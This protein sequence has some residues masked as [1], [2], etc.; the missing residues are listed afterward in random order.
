[1]RL[2]LLYYGLE[3]CKGYSAYA[4]GWI[5]EKIVVQFLGRQKISVYSRC[6]D[7]SSH[8]PIQWVW[9]TFTRAQFSGNLKIT[10][11]CYRRLSPL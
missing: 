6:P 11:V 5:T 7:R 3:Q 9:E 1:M 2:S 4:K 10:T 8:S